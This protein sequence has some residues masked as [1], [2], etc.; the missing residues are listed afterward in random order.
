M[1][2]SLAEAERLGIEQWHPDHPS[3]RVAM[4]C[5]AS[6]PTSI[7]GPSPT[8]SVRLPKVNAL[9]QNKTEARFDAILAD[10]KARG[11][12]RDS[13]FEPIA[14]RLAGRTSYRP[15][16][17][18]QRIDGSMVAIEIKGHMRDDAA[19]KVKVAADKCSWLGLYVAF[20]DGRGFD[21]RAVGRGGIGGPGSG[22]TWWEV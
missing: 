15:D 8:T 7:V 10:L 4:S 11:L 1:G 6:G 14:L 12:I 22:S 19:V 9:G 2:L 13:W 3:N 21:V 20:A 18:V 16:F 17:L 5:G